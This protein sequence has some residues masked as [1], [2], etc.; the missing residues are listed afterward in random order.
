[1]PP[2]GVDVDLFSGGQILDYE[3]RDLLEPLDLKFL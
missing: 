3:F 2:E 1:M